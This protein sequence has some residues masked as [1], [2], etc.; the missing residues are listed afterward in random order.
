M[1]NTDSWRKSTFKLE[2][3]VKPS[4]TVKREGDRRNPDP[5]ATAAKPRSA[6][7]AHRE[8]QICRE[9]QIRLRSPPRSPPRSPD[10]PRRT[11]RV[12]RGEQRL[13]G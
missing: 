8:A 13:A 12:A 9:A 7:E 1:S 4:D 6:C 11:W 2:S 3:T 5:L 10:L